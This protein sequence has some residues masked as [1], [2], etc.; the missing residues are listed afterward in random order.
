MLLEFQ[1]SAFLGSRCTER[2]EN[3]DYPSSTC[4]QGLKYW[5]ATLITANTHVCVTS[6][7]GIETANNNVGNRG[8]TGSR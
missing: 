8:I 1:T 6:P 3:D 4:E 5:L 7:G 2:N